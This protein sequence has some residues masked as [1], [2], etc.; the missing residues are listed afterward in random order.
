[1]AGVTFLL[2]RH[3]NRSTFSRAALRESIEAFEAVGPWFLTLLCLSTMGISIQIMSQ[4]VPVLFYL[5]L[6]YAS[7]LS[8]IIASPLNTVF[9][10]FMADEIFKANYQP[11]INALATVTICVVGIASTVSGVFVFALSSLAFNEKL[12]FVCLSVLL[13]LFWCIS[14]CL[15]TLQKERVLFVLFS[16]GIAVTLALFAAAKP[17]KMLTLSLTYAAGMAIPVGGGYAYAINLYTRTRVTLEWD[18]FKRRDALINGASIFIFYLGFWVDKMVF[19][20]SD[21][22]GVH[23]D[24]LFHYYPDYDFPFFIAV[25]LMMLGTVFVYRGVKRKISEPYKLFIFKLEHNFPFREIALEKY[26]LVDG[27]SHV[28]GS[29]LIFYGGII[30]FLLLLVRLG[31]ISLPWGNPYVFHYLMTGTIFF[32]MYFFY[33]MVLQ[34][35]DE[36]KVLLRINLLFFCVNLFVTVA[37]VQLGFRYYGIG[38][39]AASVITALIAFFILSSK[40]GGLEYY[41]FSKALKEA[42]KA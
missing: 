24:R 22:T 12:V 39:L 13:S 41:V 40:I 4:E 36:Y 9:T 14:T 20:F 7:A 21:E 16:I 31:N 1:M 17:M 33:F 5:S 35:L 42:D 27:V 28:S 3:V 34:Y 26:K 6:T 15:A 29:I 30:A 11:I 8:L 23:Y 32:S 10:R 19:W 38:F 2:D 18:L 25:T 37:S